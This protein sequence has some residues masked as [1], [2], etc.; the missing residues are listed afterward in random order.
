M[1]ALALRK[2]ASRG[3]DS[4]THAARRTG[5]KILIVCGCLWKGCLHT[6]TAKLRLISAK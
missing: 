3:A 6:G 1:V 5:I 2:A 4:L